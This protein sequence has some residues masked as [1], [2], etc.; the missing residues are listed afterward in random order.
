VAFVGGSQWCSWAGSAIGGPVQA[1]PG[2]QVIITATG[3]TAGT[4]YVLQWIGRSDSLSETEPSYP[5]T[6]AAGGGTGTTI[7]QPPGTNFGV[8]LV[9]GA[10]QAIG[11]NGGASTSTLLATPPAGDVYALKNATFTLG[12]GATQVQIVGN[13]TGFVFCQAFSSA[14]VFDPLMGQVAAEQLNF[15]TVGDGGSVWLSYDLIAPPTGGGG[16]VTLTFQL[17][18]TYAVPGLLAAQTLPAFFVPIM[19]GQTGVLVAARCQIQTGTSIQ[20]ELQRNGVDIGGLNAV[21]VTTT[22]TTTLASPAPA[23]G[24]NDAIQAI[25]SSLVGSPTGL[26][27][28]FYVQYT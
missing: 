21:S 16:A 11:T 25:L 23:L 26:T 19:A 20:V 28:S 1:L 2:E 24:N 14:E 3:L 6:N 4:T 27:I 17:S 22:P 15:T 9:G 7:T 13:S 10:S 5:D 12:S 8:Q 18:H